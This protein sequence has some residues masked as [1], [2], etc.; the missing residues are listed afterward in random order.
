MTPLV[1]IPAYNEEEAIVQTIH[2]ITETLGDADIVIV[3]DGSTDRTED[4]IRD[5]CGENRSIT[6]LTLPYN[7]GI[8]AAMQTGF[9]YALKNDY[10]TAIQFDGDGQHD[11]GFIADM[12]V[13]SR[14]KKLDLCIG[15]RFIESDG[16]GFRSTTARR[17]GIRFFSRLIGLLIGQNVT[18]PTSGFRVYGKAA[19]RAFA[20]NYCDDYPEP[21]S[22]FW[23]VR[24]GLKVGEFPVRMQCRQGGTSSIGLSRS[25]YYMVK[26]TAAICIDRIR[27]KE[28]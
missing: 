20:E 25:M 23:G 4:E 26:V 1:I 21:E 11:A 17:F 27:R 16:D 24:N 2:S 28:L 19:I 9:L 10:D 7:C 14:E 8:G 13:Y 22:L 15:S 18:D 3:N 6:M 5:Q 12:L